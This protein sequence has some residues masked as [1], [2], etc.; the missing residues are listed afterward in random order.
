[1]LNSSIF[2]AIVFKTTFMTFVVVLV[3]KDYG[4]EV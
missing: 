2:L 1:M 4:E 3:E